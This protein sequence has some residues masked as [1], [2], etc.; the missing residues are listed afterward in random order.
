MAAALARS[1]AAQ[2]GRNVDGSTFDVIEMIFKLLKSL[3]QVTMLV[4][5]NKGQTSTVAS[6]EY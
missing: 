4:V 5:T 3:S 2:D 6:R 1:L